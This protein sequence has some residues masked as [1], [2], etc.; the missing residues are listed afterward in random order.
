MIIGGGTYDVDN[1]FRWM[2]ER[3]GVRPGTGGRLVILR[4]VRVEED[5]YTS[6]IYYSGPRQVT[7]EAPQPRWVGGASLGLT[8]VETLV[9][10]DRV[11]ANHAFVNE[12]VGRANAVFI[13]GGDQ[14][15]YINFWKNTALHTTLNQL[16]AQ[17]TPIGGTSAGLAVLGQFDFA[18]LKD[19]VSTAEALGNPFN[20][21]MTLDPDPLSL[22]GGFLTP[23]SFRNTILDS[24]FDKRDRMGRTIA[25]VSRLVAPVGTSGCPGGIL[26]A[27][28]SALNGA[29]AIGVSENTALLVEGD[30]LRKPFTARRATNPDVATDGAIYFVRPLQA[31]EVCAAGKPLTVRGVEIG[32]LADNSVFNLSDWS[33]VPTYTVDAVNG[34]LSRN[35]Y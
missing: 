11:A 1:A 14:A 17:N 35:P 34:V 9:I 4:A 6:Y 30:G 26:A 33:G 31:P 19:G 25:F 3:S 23:D 12:I 27:G 8:S 18:A 10:P 28:T 15:N 20:E 7:N 2:I 13:S 16:M 22:T 29:R 21:F 5:D 24:H 32:K